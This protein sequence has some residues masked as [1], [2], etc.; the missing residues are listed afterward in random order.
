MTDEQLQRL[1]DLGMWELRPYRETL[2]RGDVDA[3]LSAY[4]GQPARLDLQELLES[5]RLGAHGQPIAAAEPVSEVGAAQDS[6][7]VDASCVGSGSLD[8]I[9]DLR[10]AV[11]LLDFIDQD[12]EFI[13]SGGLLKDSLPGSF[14]PYLLTAN[15]CIATQAAASTL[16]AFWDFR[17][18]SCGGAAPDLATLPRSNG[19]TLLA[20]G[21]ASSTSD[22]TLLRLAGVPDG[23]FFL[24]WNA[25]PGAVANGVKLHRISYP[26][27]GPQGYSE[28][29]VRTSGV[30]FC[31]DVPRPAF[32][33]AQDT[34]GATFG[35]SSGAPAVLSGGFVV[36]QLLGGCGADPENGCD[37]TNSELDGSF[38]IS[39][40]A[41]ARWLAPAVPTVSHIPQR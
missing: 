15:H 3:F 11:A 31:S 16:E 28:S 35:G 14:I 4:L 7:L 18:S 6:C 39:F 19:A 21:D 17:T 24:G 22:F 36:G 12:Q 1:R 26:N 33:Y 10:K 41:L 13:C 37:Y 32:V 2:Q 25:N 30:P 27:A 9:A 38:A 34:E 5:F 40:P 23:R 20:T 8:V 29:T